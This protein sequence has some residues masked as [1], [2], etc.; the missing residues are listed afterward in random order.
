MRRWL[1]TSGVISPGA[2]EREGKLNRAD[3]GQLLHACLPPGGS[4]AVGPTDVTATPRCPAATG[5]P[6]MAG[7]TSERNA[8]NPGRPQQP[9]DALAGLPLRTSWHCFHGS[10]VTTLLTTAAV[11]P[12]ESYEPT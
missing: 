9:G 12:T 1:M 10:C 2:R 8:E 11:L 4:R 3:R 7:G 6:G 5:N